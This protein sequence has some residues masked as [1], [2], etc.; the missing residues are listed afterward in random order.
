MNYLNH[1][2]FGLHSS[3]VLRTHFH[4][5][6]TYCHELTDCQT[7]WDPALHHYFLAMLPLSILNSSKPYEYQESFVFAVHFLK[8][9][10]QILCCFFF[11]SGTILISFVLKIVKLKITLKNRYFLY[12]AKK[13]TLTQTME[14]KRFLVKLHCV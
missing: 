12:V 3:L 10:A 1:S 4:Y 6:C 5:Y 7:E 13:V 11:S 14:F 9:L 8:I 2:G